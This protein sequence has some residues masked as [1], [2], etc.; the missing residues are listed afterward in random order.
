MTIAQLTLS[1]IA[2]AS[3][4]RLASW[5]HAMPSLWSSSSGEGNQAI[6]ALEKQLS[7]CG[8]ENLNIVPCPPC[9]DCQCPDVLS[10]CIWTGALALVAG[11]A[12]GY[13][14]L[15]WCNSVY[16]VSVTSQDGSTG[17]SSSQTAGRNGPRQGE[18]T[19]APPDGSSSRVLRRRGA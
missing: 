17:S 7:R 3:G 19:W 2:C 18:L 16:F 11:F 1:V 12:V 9:P 14:W 5:W 13:S 4:F 6:S 10:F 8:P 15:A